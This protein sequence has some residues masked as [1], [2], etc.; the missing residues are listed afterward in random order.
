[1]LSHSKLLLSLVNKLGVSLNHAGSIPVAVIPDLFRVRTELVIDVCSNLRIFHRIVK[2]HDLLLL[3]EVGNRI[4]I[5]RKKTDIA[6]K[7]Q[8]FDNEL[9]GDIQLIF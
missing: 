1:M 4:C 6:V 8:H 9:R 7:V 3:V 5:L 2:A